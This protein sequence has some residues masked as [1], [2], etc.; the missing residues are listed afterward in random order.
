MEDNSL[1]EWAAQG[2]YFL[3]QKKGEELTRKEIVDACGGWD[4][5]KNKTSISFNKP[6]ELVVYL[7]KETSHLDYYND[8]K[9]L[10]MGLY[11]EELDKDKWLYILRTARQ[12]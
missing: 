2:V 6:D 10:I 12:F 3:R 7:Y 8:V 4:F 5:I 9:E 1:T 11:P